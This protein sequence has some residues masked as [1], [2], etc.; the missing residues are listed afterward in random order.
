[1]NHEAWSLGVGSEVSM[2]LGLA[3]THEG[4]HHPTFYMTHDL[5]DMESL[6]DINIHKI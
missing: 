6:V 5:V 2:S 1:M 3:T 4:K